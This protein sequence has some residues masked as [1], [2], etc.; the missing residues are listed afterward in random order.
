[1]EK[2]LCYMSYQTENHHIAQTKPA[3]IINI[4]FCKIFLVS[5]VLY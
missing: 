1:M 4:V 5:N 2:L 3:L